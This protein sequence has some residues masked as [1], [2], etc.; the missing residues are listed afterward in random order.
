MAID[1]ICGMTVSENTELKAER[2]GKT[3]Y[4]CSDH[5]RTKFIA[6]QDHSEHKHHCCGSPETPIVQPTVEAKYFCPMCPGVVSDKPG[7]CPKCGMALEIN[8][9]WIS[10]D[11]TIYTCPMHP[12]IRQD[13]PGNCPLCGMALEPL[14]VP[15]AGEEKNEELAYMSRRFWI[16]AV[17]TLPV[18]ILAM[19]HLIPGVHFPISM[20]ASRL[21]QFLLSTPVVIW[22]SWPFFKRGW[23]SVVNKQLNMFTLIAI[24]VG[25]AY[26]YSAVAI[27]FPSLFPET[28]R[29]DG[30]IG[31]YFE[32]AA[33]ITVLVLLGQM[34]ELRARSRTSSA[35][36]ALINLSPKTAHLVKNDNETEV[37]LAQIKVG[38]LLR[39]RPG[40]KVPVDGII[41]EGRTTIDE[42]MIT[43]ESMPI[44]KSAGDKVT[45]ATLNNVGSFLMKAERI[46]QDT[47]LSHIVRM[48]ADAQRSRAPIQATGDKVA[49]YFVPAV[50]LISVLTFLTWIWIGPEPKLSYAIVTAVS[51]LIIACPCA[52]GLAT[53]MSIM[54][55]IGRGAQSGILI[56]N[57]SSIELLERVDTLVVDKTGT[58][59]EGKPR[60]TKCI[61]VRGISEKV[62]I[63]AAASVEQYSEHPIASAIVYGAKE[64]DIILETVHDFSSTTGGGVTGKLGTQQVTVG[65]LKFLREQGVDTQAFESSTSQIQSEGQTLIFVGLD[66]QAAGIL[67]VSD[68]IKTTSFEAIENLHALGIRIVML[69][70]DNET[71]ALSVAKKLNID[72][73]EANVE[74]GDKIG[75]VQQLREQKR[76]VA[77]AAMALMTLQ[78]WLQLT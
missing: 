8:P 33:V 55:G 46:G 44:D 30:E 2:D 77:M 35:I 41:I 52:L 61:S 71:T 56:K 60:L 67:S 31:V 43:G 25:T 29:H 54:V 3:Y 59:T 53:P 69:T 45:G 48:V 64:R 78:H 4:F 72:E 10:P 70:G 49:A 42:S 57:A 63:K 51:V 24:G 47:V 66:K 1:P 50:L 74:P 37:P 18:F 73:V 62:L 58:L 5:C 28:F 19:A 15:S 12:E 7:D 6:G 11:K 22:G 20:D 34:L 26:F 68:P 23:A 21:V 38:D 36:R 27:F 39:V 76:V 65:K 32:A 40:E 17:L 9:R 14:N 16:S 75:R 13:H